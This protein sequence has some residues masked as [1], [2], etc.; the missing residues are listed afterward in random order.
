MCEPLTRGAID[1]QTAQVLAIEQFLLAYHPLHAVF[2]AP[3]T[4]PNDDDGK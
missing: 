4:D 1:P 3:N 2:Y